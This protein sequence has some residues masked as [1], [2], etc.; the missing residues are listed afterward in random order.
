MMKTPWGDDAVG[1]LPN[2]NDATMSDAVETD[3]GKLDD[4]AP[5]KP[6]TLVSAKKSKK[7]FSVPIIVN[8][9]GTLFHSGAGKPVCPNCV[10]HSKVV[11]GMLKR[12]ELTA[13]VTKGKAY[14]QTTTCALWH[15]KDTCRDGHACTRKICCFNHEGC[16]KTGASSPEKKESPKV[17]DRDMEKLYLQLELA[18]LENE[19][20]LL[21]QVSK[22]VSA[23]THVDTPVP[24]SPIKREECWFYKQ[25][26]C[27]YG[28]MCT[29]LHT[30]VA[31]K[32]TPVSAPT[33]PKP[34]CKNFNSPT[35]CK[36]GNKCHFEHSV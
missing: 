24:S 17:A 13:S 19:N 22:Q 8:D 5:E 25:G 15:P 18:K 35:G 26:K 33:S 12:L 27:T 36:F 29:K 16:P 2:P 14:C 20:L 10:L 28:D 9:D 21:K 6:F 23:A 4:T 31:E 3:D 7:T 1:L 32:P 30:P 11:D 34:K